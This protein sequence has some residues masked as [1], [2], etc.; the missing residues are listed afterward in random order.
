MNIIYTYT[1]LLVHYY[2]MSLLNFFC[3]ARVSVWPL[4]SKLHSLGLLHQFHRTI[5]RLALLSL[6][7]YSAFEGGCGELEIA[8]VLLQERGELLH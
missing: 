3:F 2:I 5:E 6:K 8:G 4:G 1:E 7:L